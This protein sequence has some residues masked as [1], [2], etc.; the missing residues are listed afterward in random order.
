MKQFYGV[1]VFQSNERAQSWMAVCQDAYYALQ[2][3]NEDAVF[4]LRESRKFH[5]DAAALLT[6][7]K[8]LAVL[9]EEPAQ[10]AADWPREQA[11]KE[12]LL[13]LGLAEIRFKRQAELLGEPLRN[14]EAIA[15]M[16]K[17][18][19]ALEKSL[20]D[21]EPQPPLAQPNMG[22]GAAKEAAGPNPFIKPEDAGAGPSSE[23]RKRL[24]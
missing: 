24:S 13:Q 3:P 16:N 18:R 11:S 14:F 2:L 12:M 15:N 21:L 4:H 6:R 1:C 5:G 10:Y 20:E 19:E 9:A 23:K 7:N 22:K 8:R 17:R